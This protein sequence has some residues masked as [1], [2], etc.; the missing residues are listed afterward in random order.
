MGIFDRTD[1]AEDTGLD[2]AQDEAVDGEDAEDAG[3]Q[4]Q[5]SL[6]QPVQSTDDET[7]TA[8]DLGTPELREEAARRVSGVNQPRDRF[9][10][11][12]P[13]PRR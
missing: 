13:P 2:V 4:D 6:D 11:E 9:P 3:F 1:D 8:Q 10:W 12:V 5:G 7:E